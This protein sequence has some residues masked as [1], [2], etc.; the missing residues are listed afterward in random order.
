M[1]SKFKEEAVR[2]FVEVA[3]EFYL[4]TGRVAVDQWPNPNV[5]GLTEKGLK[6]VQTFARR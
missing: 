2:E 4:R 1:V 5:Y 6:W 3:I